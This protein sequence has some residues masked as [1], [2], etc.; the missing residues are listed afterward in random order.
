[1]EISRWGEVY[2]PPCSANKLIECDLDDFHNHLHNLD[3]LVDY[4]LSERVQKDLLPLLR[5]NFI[6]QSSYRDPGGLMAAAAI[7]YYH[8]L[9]TQMKV[10][11][12]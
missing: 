6:G 1:M 5:E 9:V 12:E 2:R 11:W 3:I 4:L 8:E 7:K 10:S